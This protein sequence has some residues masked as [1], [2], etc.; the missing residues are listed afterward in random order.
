[1][2]ELLAIGILIV[3]GVIGAKL[4]NK[5]RLPSVVGWLIIGAILGQSGLKLF[6]PDFLE[7]VGFISDITLGLIGFI[8]GVEIT[9]AT[10]RRLGGGIISVILAQLFGAFILVFIGVWLLTHDIALALLFGALAPASAPAGT[11]AVLQEYKADGP[12]TKA[13]LIV[14]GVDDALAIMIYVF[15]ASYAKVLVGNI[16]LSVAGMIGKPLLEILLA[17]GIGGTLGWLLG[18]STQKIGAPETL[19]PVSI[20]VILICVGLSKLLHFS[21][22]IFILP[23]Y[24]CFFALAGAHLDFSL[25]LKIG[26]LGMIYIVCRSSGKIGGAWLSATIG[27]QPPTIRKYLGLGILSQAG[28]AVGLA[29][30]VNREFVPLGPSGVR[31]SSIILT[32]IAATTIVFE[33]IGPICT[34]IAI[35][36]AGE[37]HKK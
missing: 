4:I 2:N 22:Q 29:Y 34:K 23:F 8:I 14:V 9:V 5:L 25:L 19:L 16:H 20:G 12:L 15:A 11:V 27:K 37:L 1:M 35:T 32:I 28:V 26:L 33:I 21:L 6:T 30:L 3:I 10:L 24:V 17:V 36:K 7:R 18:F 31:I 13:L